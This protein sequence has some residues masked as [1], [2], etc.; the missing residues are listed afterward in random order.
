MDIARKIRTHMKDT[1]RTQTY[2]CRQIGLSSTAMSLALGGKR[3]IRL[4]EYC[5]ICKA[6]DVEPGFFLS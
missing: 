3:R 4:D 2:L 1:G 5:K 6:L